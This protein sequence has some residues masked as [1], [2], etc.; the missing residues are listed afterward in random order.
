M[1]KDLNRFEKLYL[2]IGITINLIISWYTKSAFLAIVNGILSLFVG[3]YNAKGKMIV[4][5]FTIVETLAYCVLSWQQKYYSEVFIN[6]CIH[7]PITIWSIINWSRNQ[8][9]KTETITVVTQTR[10]QLIMAVGSQVLLSFVYYYFFKMVG[11][12]MLLVSTINMALTILALYFNAIMSEYTFVCF[13]ASAAF[14][15]TLWIAP[16]LKGDLSSVPVLVGSIMYIVIDAYGLYNW[17][18]LKKEQNQ[19]AH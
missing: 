7:M 6:V 5:V 19:S 10:K 3:V 4:F 15:S 14:K 13:L 18:K 11:N 9:K 1:F 16:I 2:I 17:R 12:E 8:N